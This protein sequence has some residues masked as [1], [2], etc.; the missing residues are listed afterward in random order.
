MTTKEKR[1]VFWYLV[2]IIL[3]SAVLSVWGSSIDTTPIVLAIEKAGI[4]APII[5]ILVLAI[6]SILAPISGSPI[7]FAGY[8]MFGNKVQVLAYFSMLLSS[9]IN[10]Y[11]ARK[12]GRA[13]VTRIVGKDDMK[14]VDS[15]MKDNGLSSLIFLRIFMGIFH[16]FVS[17]A[18]GLT[19]IK[20]FPYMIVNILAPIPW[21]MIFYYLIF[22]RIS[23]VSDFFIVYLVSLIPFLIISW[24]Y[25][26]YKNKKK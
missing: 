16:D 18:Y 9:I 4:F 13:W 17:Y 12:W 19:N 14:K 15:F 20:L 2:L 23:S 10:F 1:K 26:K 3:S 5:Y 7:Y 6:P 21:L 24:F 8:I 25:W 22:P 11:I